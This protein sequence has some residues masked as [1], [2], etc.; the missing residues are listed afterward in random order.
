A[1]IVIDD[2][3][4]LYVAQEVERGSS[5]ERNAEVGQL[6]KLDPTKPDDPI[7]WSVA[8]DDGMWAMPAIADGV[9]YAPT[10]SGRIVG[11]DQET[12]EILWEKDLPGPTWSSPVVVDDVWIQG[13]CNGTLHGFDVSDPRTEPEELW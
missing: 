11:V 10:D 9:V 4:M 1:S 7:V 5:S 8:D 12:G 3:G 2:E 13:D 6:V